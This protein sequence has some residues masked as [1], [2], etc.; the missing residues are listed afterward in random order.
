MAD[1][2]DTGG[3][4]PPAPPEPG[5]P[6]EV[7]PIDTR[8][9]GAWLLLEGG[10]ERARHR[11]LVLPAN[12]ATAEFYRPMLEDPALVDAGVRMLAATPPGFGGR[13]LDARFGYTVEAYAERIDALARR[14]AVDLLVAHSLSAQ[15]ALEVA[16]QGSWRGGLV[17]VSPTLRAADEESAAR[18]LA[19]VSRVPV[20]RTAAWWAMMRAI[21][22]GLRDDLPPERHAALVAEVRRNPTRAH[23][24]WTVAGFDHV[25]HHGDLTPVAV[26]AARGRVVAV[27]RGEA[28]RL[29]LS[30][31]S[32]AALASAGV[33]VV[34]VPGAGHF[35]PTQQ[36]EAV[37]EVVLDV[38]RRG[39][40]G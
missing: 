12:L 36:P 20:M 24:R 19:N 4:E 5:V 13:P 2:H 26:A 35:V 28:D 30:A 25:R 7:H 11:V 22:V 39:A 18:S 23:R 29:R 10:A 15:A 14:E 9:V 37:N 38:L 17:L 21:G 33:R 31:A 34:D 8:E 6:A 32:R 27:V 40:P 3:A 16:T 1:Q